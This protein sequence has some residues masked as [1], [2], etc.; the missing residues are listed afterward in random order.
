MIAALMMA[1]KVD[2]AEN[3]GSLVCQFSHVNSFQAVST[4]TEPKSQQK[5]TKKMEKVSQK[6]GD[7]S[8]HLKFNLNRPKQPNIFT[9]VLSCEQIFSEY[10]HI[11]CKQ[12]IADM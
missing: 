5:T 1:L 9:T 12:E 10:D 4:S 8:P 11:L 6:Q 3:I 2:H 7:E